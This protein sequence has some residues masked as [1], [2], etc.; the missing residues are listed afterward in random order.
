MSPLCTP[1]NPLPPSLLPSLPLTLPTPGGLA[2]AHHWPHT[3]LR[4]LESS[5]HLLCPEIISPGGRSQSSPGSHHSSLGQ[6]AGHMRRGQKKHDLLSTYYG[7]CKALGWAFH[8][9]Y[10]SYLVLIGPVRWYRKYSHFTNGETDSESSANL[11]KVTQLR[12]GRSGIRS[13]V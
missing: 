11:P 7:M 13:Q 8:T 9:Y 3:F 6:C 4:P 10:F 5:S 2:Q 1:S 12:S